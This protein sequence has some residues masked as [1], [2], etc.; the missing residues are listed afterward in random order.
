MV[1]KWRGHMNGINL[2]RSLVEQFAQDGALQVM[3]EWRCSTRGVDQPISFGQQG[4]PTARYLSIR[5]VLDN[6]R[7]PVSPSSK[8]RKV[9][10]V[11]GRERR[12]D[13]LA[14]L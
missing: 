4:S 9:L 14:V 1:K 7:H 11:F 2:F 6:F 12:K 8:C 13:F 5:D 3:N 10:L